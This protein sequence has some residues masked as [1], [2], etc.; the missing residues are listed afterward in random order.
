MKDKKEAVANFTQPVESSAESNPLPT[1]NCTKRRNLMI[2]TGEACEV[3]FLG[4]DSDLFCLFLAGWMLPVMSSMHHHHRD[5]VP[6][7]T[8][9]HT[10]L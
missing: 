2:V 7:R 9:L 4:L 10:V 6:L 1:V 3:L 5:I 8:R